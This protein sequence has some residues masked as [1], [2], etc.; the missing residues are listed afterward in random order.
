MRLD[1]PRSGGVAL[2]NALENAPENALESTS[3][4]TGFNRD[5]LHE[6]EVNIPTRVY[7]RCI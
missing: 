4:S 5:L 1:S 7:S 6:F 2:E 3:P